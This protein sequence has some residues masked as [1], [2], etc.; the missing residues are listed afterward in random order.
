[1]RESSA[2]RGIWIGVGGTPGWTRRNGQ[3]C[4]YGWKGLGIESRKQA[5]RGGGRTCEER[6]AMAVREPLGRGLI[7][8]LEGGDGRL[9]QRGEKG[10][11]MVIKLQQLLLLNLSPKGG[12]RVAVAS[13][14]YMTSMYAYS[15]NAPELQ[16]CPGGWPSLALDW[17]PFETPKRRRLLIAWR[18]SFP[19]ADPDFWTCYVGHLDPDLYPCV[20]LDFLGHLPALRR[21]SP[22]SCSFS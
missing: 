18:P 12:E 10:Y 17:W 15:R 21:Y 20:H 6:G 9:G 4:G 22:D 8:T 14:A 13:V 16:S 2:T 7:G 11:L 3:R 19:F 1:M 5:E